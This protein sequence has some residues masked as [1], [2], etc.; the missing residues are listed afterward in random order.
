MSPIPT[1][2]TSGNP[3]MAQAVQDAMSRYGITS[4]AGGVSP[5]ARVA[6]P[7]DQPLPPSQVDPA[8]AAPKQEFQPATQ[9]DLII[10]SLTEQLGRNNK[11]EKE[12]MK[13]AA[14]QEAPAAPQM[15]SS[16]PSSPVQ[17]QGNYPF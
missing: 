5:D 2:Q 15:P 10:M 16:P 1:P 8:P 17:Q 9:D 7:T 4:Q 11:L 3:G 12:K 6:N 13:M 14:P